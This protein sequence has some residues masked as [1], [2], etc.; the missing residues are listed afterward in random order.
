MYY[1][2]GI[3]IIVGGSVCAST[4]DRVVYFSSPI[5][6]SSPGVWISSCEPVV[7]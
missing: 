2:M 3:S 6:W 5:G 4:D 1:S 7:S